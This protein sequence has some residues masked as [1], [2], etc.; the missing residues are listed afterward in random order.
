MTMDPW[1]GIEAMITRADL[2]DEFPVHFGRNR[3]S[4]TQALYTR[5]GAKALRLDNETGSI[6]AR[7]IG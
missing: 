2:T 7:K 3:Q 4:S 6:E 5:G 1:V